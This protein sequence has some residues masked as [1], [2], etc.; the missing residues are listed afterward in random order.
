M[1]NKKTLVIL[2]LAFV[3]LL[4]G[5]YVLY[6]RLGDSLNPDRLA[7]QNDPTLSE[8]PSVTPG[9]AAEETAPVKTPA[10]DFTVYDGEGREVHL[11]DYVGKPIVVNFWASWCGPCQMEMPDFQ[12]KYLELGD[13]IHFLMINMTGGRETVESAAA[14]IADNEYTFPVF[15]DTQTHAAVTYGAYSLPM[16]F[17]IDAE[18]YVVAQATGMIDSA[19]LQQGIDM[20]LPN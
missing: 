19:I 2:L 10:P 14:F 16:T 1:K 11:R 18:G 12:E 5:A 4:A 6:D 15:Y 13:Q 7:V 9:G 8:T 17:F 20:I 3:L